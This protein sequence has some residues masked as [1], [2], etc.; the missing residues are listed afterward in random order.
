MGAV[1]SNHSQ[2]REAKAEPEEG[3]DERLETAQ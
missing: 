1:Q 3:G 2:I